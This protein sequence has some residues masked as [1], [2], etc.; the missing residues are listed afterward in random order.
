V[1]LHFKLIIPLLDNSI[2]KNNLSTKAGFVD[3]FSAD[4]NRPYLDNHIFLLYA[5][6][7]LT[8]EAFDTYK[9]L[10]S[11]KGLYGVYKFKIK[12]IPF[13]MFAFTITNKTIKNIMSGAVALSDV[14]KMR[15]FAFWNLQD[16]DINRY[17]L[18]STYAWNSKFV[19]NVIPEEDYQPDTEIFW[20]KKSGA[21]QYRSVPL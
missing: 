21:L 3:A 2:T 20:D 5:Y 19:N 11:A 14:E 12:G 6:N 17:M 15:V 7:V 13:I 9:K 4:I 18:N 16:S 8:N 1:S 10:K